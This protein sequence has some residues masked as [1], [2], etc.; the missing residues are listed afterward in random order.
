M[1]QYQINKILDFC[2]RFLMHPHGNW[3]PSIG[4]PGPGTFLGCLLLFYAP[5]KP[6]NC[7]ETDQLVG[8][9][10]I[11]VCRT[12]SMCTTGWP[13]T[14]LESHDWMCRSVCPEGLTS[15]PQN[16]GLTPRQRERA[17][18]EKLAGSPPE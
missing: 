7:T 6:K 10:S 4:G 11:S 12:A 17:A 18:G 3:R 5:K 9:A 13:T 15:T 14:G 2:A 16:K 8:A 1:R